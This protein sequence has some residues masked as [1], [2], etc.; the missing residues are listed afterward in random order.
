M[1]AASA[2]RWYQWYTNTQQKFKMLK[3]YTELRCTEYRTAIDLFGYFT[4]L[5]VDMNYEYSQ[6]CSHKFFFPNMAALLVRET[7]RDDLPHIPKDA[8][9]YFMVTGSE[10]EV[11]E[12]ADDTA[13]HP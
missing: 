2:G 1:P 12:L 7:I 9:R 8:V 4:R 10:T 5:G 6:G 11:R 13:Q 3:C